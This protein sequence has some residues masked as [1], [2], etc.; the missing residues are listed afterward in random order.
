MTANT[1]DPTAPQAGRPAEGEERPQ[2]PERR[3]VP[4]Q[5]DDD[6]VPDHRR[7]DDSPGREND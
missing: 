2:D 7:S 3:S 4:P 1:T 6:V 5:P